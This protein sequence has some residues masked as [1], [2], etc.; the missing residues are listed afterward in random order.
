MGAI[1]LL[2]SALGLGKLVKT[3][4]DIKKYGDFGEIRIGDDSPAE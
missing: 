2:M 4:G 3:N 1:Q